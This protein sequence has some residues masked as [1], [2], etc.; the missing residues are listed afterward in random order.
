MSKR[1]GGGFKAGGGCV[2]LLYAQYLPELIFKALLVLVGLSFILRLFCIIAVEQV[3]D[4]FGESHG[5]VSRRQG[6]CVG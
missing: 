3:I 4:T 6:L 2:R 1:R 5:S